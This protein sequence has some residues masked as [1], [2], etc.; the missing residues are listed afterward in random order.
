MGWQVC[1]GTHW[2]S[3]RARVAE[4]YSSHDRFISYV[5]SLEAFDLLH[6]I[7]PHDL[8]CCVTSRTSNLRIGQPPELAK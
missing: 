8:R 7:W 3:S 2:G 4:M 1:I 5:N 6:V